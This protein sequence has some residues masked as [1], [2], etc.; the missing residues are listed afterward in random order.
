MPMITFDRDARARVR[1]R[2]DASRFYLHAKTTLANDSK[3]RLL[4][5]DL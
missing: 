3:I 5:S 4:F 2:T 1:S